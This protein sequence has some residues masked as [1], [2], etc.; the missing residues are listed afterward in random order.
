MFRKSQIIDLFILAAEPSADL[1]GAKLIEEILRLRPNLKIAAV[2]GP[3]MRQLPIE[4]LFPMESLQVMGFIDVFAALPRIAKQFFSI[5]RKNPQAKPKSRP[6][7]RLSGLQ[8]P[9]GALPS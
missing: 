6:F 4:T 8:S 2:A 5:R 3:R 7:H 1:H 9:A